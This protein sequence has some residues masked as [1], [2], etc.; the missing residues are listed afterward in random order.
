MGRAVR[1]LYRRAGKNVRAEDTG[2]KMVEYVLLCAFQTRVRRRGRGV[3][4]APIESLI[5][6]VEVGRSNALMTETGTHALQVRQ[7]RILL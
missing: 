4:V 3:D 6:G 1:L 7:T 5:E 2:N